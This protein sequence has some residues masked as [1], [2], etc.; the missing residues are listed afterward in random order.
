VAGDQRAALQT[1]FAAAG[2]GTRKF[3]AADIPAVTQLFY[4]GVCGRVPAGCDARSG[5]GERHP[6]TRLFGISVRSAG[7]AIARS[8]GVKDLRL[9]DPACAR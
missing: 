3:A 8:I 9:I 1:A 5:M 4:A 6:D 2:K 7:A